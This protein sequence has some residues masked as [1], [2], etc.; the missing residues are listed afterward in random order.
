MVNC[1]SLV[2]SLPSKII[3]KTKTF[4]SNIAKQKNLSN[5]FFDGETKVVKSS[6][7]HSKAS[8]KEISSGFLIGLILLSGFLSL[9]FSTL[10]IHPANNPSQEH[11]AKAFFADH[12]GFVVLSEH[13]VSNGWSQTFSEINS[14]QIDWL[15]NLVFN[16]GDIQFFAKGSSY[17]SESLLIRPSLI[18]TDIIFPFHSHW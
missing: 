15:K 7:I 1:F 10:S 13:K 4:G 9:R 14:L 11:T 16:F 3:S 17:L 2:K 6:V 5:H 8:L 18:V 12:P